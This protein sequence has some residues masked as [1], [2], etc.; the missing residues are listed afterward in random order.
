MATS[1]WPLWRKSPTTM[2]RG[3]SLIRK[4]RGGWKVPSPLP[5]SKFTLVE[6]PGLAVTTSGMPSPLK[7]PTDRAATPPPASKDIAAWKLSKVRLSSSS[8]RKGR[9]PDG[10][11]PRGMRH[12][13][14]LRRQPVE[15]VRQGL[16][17]LLHGGGV[18]PPRGGLLPPPP[19]PQ[20]GPAPRHHNRQP[21]PPRPPEPPPP[22]R[23]PPPP[24]PGGP[25]GR[26]PRPGPPAR[27]PRGRPR[28]GRGGGPPGARPPPG[29]R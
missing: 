24:P 11:L 9:A 23:G 25:R 27:P 21:P 14:F 2:E 4:L 19:P 20:E 16:L 28:P 13:L 3:I 12:L 15:A 26:P 5:K 7:S 18:A 6:K 22:P 29:R 8:T 10:V 1:R 17:S